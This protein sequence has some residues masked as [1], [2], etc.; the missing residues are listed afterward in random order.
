MGN[1]TNFYLPRAHAIAAPTIPPP[2]I[3]TCCGSTLE[4]K[5]RLKHCHDLKC[6]RWLDRINKDEN[7]MYTDIF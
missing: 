5:K 2:V 7:I 4:Q 1:K 6:S 3:T